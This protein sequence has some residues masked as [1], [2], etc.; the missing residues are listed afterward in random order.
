MDASKFRGAASKPRWFVLEAIIIPSRLAKPDRL[1]WLLVCAQSLHLPRQRAPSQNKADQ[2]ILE[3][4]PGL[5]EKR[6]LINSCPCA[7]QY[8][9]AF[10][11]HTPLPAELTPKCRIKDPRQL[12]FRCLGVSSPPPI[13]TMVLRTP[14]S[15]NPK[16]E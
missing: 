8:Y 11:N 14:Y 6:G 9:F 5:S 13:R 2:P 4:P 3:R 16:R 7:H 1:R 15:S 10:H 12:E